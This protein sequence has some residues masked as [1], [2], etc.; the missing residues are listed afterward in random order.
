MMDRSITPAPV[1]QSLFV[2]AP[3]AR[4][5]AIFT[6]GMGGWWPKSHSINTSPLADIRIEPRPGGRWQEIGAD[7]SVCD[8]GRVALWEPPGRVIL[9]WQISADWQFDPALETEVEVTFRPEAGGTRVSLVHRGL[10]AYGARAAEMS[11]VFGS[12]SGWP[13][14]LALYAGAI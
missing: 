14:M 4:A 7:G 1:T 10:E 8:W 2:P 13:G 5:F 12:P 9:V 11:G 3:P 6:E